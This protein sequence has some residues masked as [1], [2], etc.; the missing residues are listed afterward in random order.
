MTSYQ[1]GLLTTFILGL[2]ILIGA[3]ISLLI[4]KKD[5]IVNFSLGLAFGVIVT[6]IITDLL[7]EIYETLRLKY[8][9]LFIIFTAVGYFLLK[10][11]DGFIPDHQEHHL[12]K[13]ESTANLAHVG[14]MTTMAI[15]LHNI[16]E[17]MA[18]YSTALTDNS[19]AVS[20][21][22]GV[23]FHNIPLGM[24]IASSL[25][26]SNKKKYKTLIYILLVSISTFCGGLIM[27]CFKFVSLNDIVLGIL[28]S[29]TLGML[30]FIV[31]DELLPRIKDT[32]KD[33]VTYLGIVLG[34][35]LI[36]V[37]LLIG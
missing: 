31:I 15:V 22:I 23:G 37:S 8:I 30:I 4:T 20:L 34:V 3:G 28:L 33:K 13:K 16:I 19:L 12:N 10:I 11:L 14:I 7:P 2:F 32:K 36:V 35:C 1:V 29:I 6:L 25:Y 27:Y 5:K 17:G 26:H 24:V 21:S 18:V 9:Y